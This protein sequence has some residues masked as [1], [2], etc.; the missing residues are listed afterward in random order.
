MID[1]S[2]THKDFLYLWDSVEAQS[3]ANQ[4]TTLRQ[5][6]IAK[7][8]LLI[9][10]TRSRKQRGE[11]LDW[12]FDQWVYKMGHPV[13]KITKSYDE[14]KHELTLSV[15][16]IQ[17]ID[18]TESCPQVEFFQGKIEFEIDDKIEQVTLKP[19][20]ENVFSFQVSDRPK[21]VNF[22]YNSVWI[23][24]IEFAKPLE[25][26]LYQLR[27][28]KDVLGKSQSLISTLN[29]LREL[30]DPRG[31]EVAM[32]ALSDKTLPRWW[33]A[34]PTWD[35]PIAAIETIVTLNKRESAFP[36]CLSDSKLQWPTMTTTISSQMHC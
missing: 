36:V 23:K 31:Y 21:L 3:L 7:S 10:K 18:A 9:F 29:G 13:F 35:Y 15:K 28:D 16:Q 8:Q 4:G 25:E 32:N 22:D 20:A 19:L 12:F 33:L 14:S 26:L 11:S 2:R 24:E 34:V 30:D 5:T 27:H 17:E 6:R 1:D